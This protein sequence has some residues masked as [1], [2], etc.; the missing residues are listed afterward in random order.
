[1]NIKSHWEKTEN[2]KYICIYI[3]ILYIFHTYS[4]YIYIYSVSLEN[5][6]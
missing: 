6:D 2:R 3:Y 1:M 4:E 5:L